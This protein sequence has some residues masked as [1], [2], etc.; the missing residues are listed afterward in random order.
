MVGNIVVSVRIIIRVVRALVEVYLR[1]DG[2]EGEVVP[3]EGVY[4]MEFL[5][6]HCRVMEDQDLLIKWMGLYINN[7]Q[8]C[9]FKWLTKFRHE[10]GQK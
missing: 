10:N 4:Q 2:V 5:M 8:G 1:L 6:Q 3:R 7:M 9:I